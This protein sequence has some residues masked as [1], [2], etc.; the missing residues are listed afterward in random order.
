[1]KNNGIRENNF[2]WFENYL[3]NQKQFISFNSKHTCFAD[4]ICG[5]PQRSI[6]G[7]L[8]FLIYVNDLNRA[9]DI[10]DPITFADNTNLFYSHK[11][12]K[13]FFRTVN[14]QLDKVKHWFKVIKLLLNV[15]E[16]NHT[17]FHKPSPKDDIP[18][19]IPK[20]H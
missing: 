13:M 7:L 17:F 11:D 12:D 20:I 14:T 16:A 5:V 3:K 15:K 4:R 2:K 10:L 9:S 6:L 8:S 1:M 19:K 18:L